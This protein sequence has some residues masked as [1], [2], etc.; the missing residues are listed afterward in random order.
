M[1]VQGDLLRWDSRASSGAGTGR[2]NGPLKSFCCSRGDLNHL[3][4]GIASC[5]NAQG[6]PGHF[7]FPLNNSFLLLPLPF[8]RFS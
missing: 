4:R 7:V 1:R 8:N 2:V 6:A 5:S 3:T